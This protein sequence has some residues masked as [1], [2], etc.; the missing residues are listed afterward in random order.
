[1]D[2]LLNT[3]NYPGGDLL[4]IT[5][6]QDSLCA[7]IYSSS[8]PPPLET[9][10]SASATAAAAAAAGYYNFKLR[11]LCLLSSP[12]ERARARH[13]IYSLSFGHTMLKS[14]KALLVILAGGVQVQLSGIPESER[15]VFFFDSISL[16]EILTYSLHRAH[17]NRE[18]SAVR[19]CGKR[20]AT[21][22]KQININYAP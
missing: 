21:E 22:T 2:E 14:S 3:G 11:L 19:S 4:I 6:R 10:R 18:I 5:L 17:E 20:G 7:C 13:Y 8:P 9:A 16:L 15:A 12:S 1:M